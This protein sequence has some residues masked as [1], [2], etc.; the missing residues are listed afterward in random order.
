M[1]SGLK[2]FWIA[3]QARR[4]GA[5]TPAATPVRQPEVAKAATCTGD[6]RQTSAGLDG[7]FLK[8]LGISDVTGSFTLGQLIG[9]STIGALLGTGMAENHRHA[10][11]AHRSND[12]LPSPASRL[13][14][15]SFDWSA[16]NAV[17][18]CTASD[19]ASDLSSSGS[20]D[21]SCGS[22]D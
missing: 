14:D 8:S 19:W 15:S 7:D 1:W 9:G 12:E 16:A 21:C 18:S 11:E 3:R 6:T 4:T 10:Q 5:A 13:V 20:T 2:R 17:V 22:G